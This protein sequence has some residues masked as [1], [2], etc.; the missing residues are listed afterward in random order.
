MCSLPILPDKLCQAWGV[1]WY[2]AL[3]PFSQARSLFVLGRGPSLGIALEAA[4]KFKETCGIHAEAFS[5]AEVAHG[6]MAVVDRN[7]PILVFPPL[8]EARAGMDALL[9]LF[10]E[11]GAIVEGAGAVGKGAIE[12]AVVAD[13]H[14]VTT[15]IAMIQCFYC[16][17]NAL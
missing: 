5:T 17:S 16:F 2:E 9:G 7:F 14:P 1:S 13:V 10:V 4:M 8:D 11:K 15:A 12:L 3:V 6:P